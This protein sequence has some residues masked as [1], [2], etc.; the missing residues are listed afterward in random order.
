[1]YS[2]SA[3]KEIITKDSDEYS[4]FGKPYS[5]TNND[6]VD[7]CLPGSFLNCPKVAEL[8]LCPSLMAQ[9]CAQNWDKK[10]ELYANT[11]NDNIMLRDF[12]RDT[13][14]K[15][16]C[17][18]SS[19]SNCTKMCQPFDPIAQE[20]P[21]VC[22]YVGNEVL[23][24]TN[25]NIDIG[26]Y[27]PVNMSP[28]YMSPCQQ[29]CNLLNPSTIT[30]SDNVINSCLKYGFCNDILTNICQLSNDSNTKIN[31]PGLSTYCNNLP[32]NSNK[33]I[34]NQPV[35]VKEKLTQSPQRIRPQNNYKYKKKE[36]IDHWYFI[37][38]ILIAL[39]LY[40]LWL[41]YKKNKRL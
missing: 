17:Q 4:D 16:Y 11:L 22:S 25:D 18:L 12:I 5:S 40:M 35:Q 30:T 37:L 2:S 32:K 38:I 34:I 27:L 14:S 8:G 20:S 21:Q 6:P 33:P 1:M 13:A 29:T 26:W 3:R 41:K 10:C 36:N 9:R 23:K 28:D 19:D 31:H 24:N 7:C 39:C 15:K